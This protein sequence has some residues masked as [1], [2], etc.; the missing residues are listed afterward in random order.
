MRRRAAAGKALLADGRLWPLARL[1]TTPAPGRDGN[2]TDTPGAA[3]VAHRIA[4]LIAAEDPARPLTDTAL[5]TILA[6]EGVDMARRTVAKYR[7]GLRIPS[8]PRR[9]ER[10]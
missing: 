7:H 6:S 1:F 3:A 4:T 8:A 2:A 5:Q 9:R 10:N